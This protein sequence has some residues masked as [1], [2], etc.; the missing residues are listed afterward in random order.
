MKGRSAYDGIV[1][2]GI[3]LL[4]GLLF[5][6]FLGGVSLFDWDEIN[7]AESAREMIVS[8]DYL[9]VQVNFIPFWEKPPL[10]IWMQAVSMHLFGVNEFAAR[11]PNAVCG[12]ITLPVLYSIGKR[13]YDS[14]FG[15]IW[16][17]TYAGSLLPF[18]YFKSGIIDPWFNLF[19]FLGIYRIYLYFTRDTAG[20]LNVSLSALFIG[21]AILTK[22]PVALLVF[23]LTVMAYIIVKKFAVKI[24]VAD[25]L[26]FSV[27]LVITGGFWF[28][29]QLLNGNFSIIADFIAYQVNLFRTRGA[30]HGGFPLYHVIV[31]LAG[32]FPAS[33]LAIPGLFKSGVG[34][35][36]QVSLAVF[37]KILFWVVLILFSIVRTK[38]VHYSSLCYFPLTFLAATIIHRIYTGGF[39]LKKYWIWM[40][41]AMGIL[42][43]I[44]LLIIPFFD[45]LKDAML[46]LLKIEDPFTL[47]CLQADAGWKGFEWLPAIVL[48]TGVGILLY[49]VLKSRVM[50]G[51][52]ALF[53]CSCLFIYG[54]LL[55]I[56]PRI[57]RYSQHAAVEFFRS[58]SHEDA[59]LETLGYKSYTHLF[60][61]Q[62]RPASNPGVLS[63]EWLLT[64]D[65]DKKVYGSMKI[66]K[67]DRYLSLFPE[68]KV[69]YEKNGFVFFVRE[70]R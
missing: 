40:I 53:L 45:R 51:L 39:N 8:G 18:L 59:Y 34:N 70:P 7:F 46:D 4:A 42:Y 28:L 63:R 55:F 67:K 15:F 43:S 56:T 49:C 41:S 47:A 25:M 50:Q 12:I 54:S 1:Y 64:G 13:I 6:P 62:A 35:D 57:E 16:I 2:T 17:M 52:Q 30:G 31:L 26:L 65:I 33:I 24:S 48:L 69:L 58:V 61:G 14:A 68:I 38:I 32:V 23:L 66:D 36:R 9:T 10:F 29:L 19:I 21:L 5:I 27:I 44:I 11:F 20:R 22:G 37:M 60:Y 3:A